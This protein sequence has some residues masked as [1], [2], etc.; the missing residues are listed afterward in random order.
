MT[1]RTIHSPFA[2]LLLRRLEEQGHDVAA[3]AQRFRLRARAGVVPALE[4]APRALHAL[5]ELAAE[6]LG[7]PD[8]GLHL[9]CA[10]PPGVFGVLELI[11]RYS[12]TL[13]D[14]LERL[15]RHSALVNPNASF[16]LERHDEGATFSHRIHGQPLAIGRHGNE[17]F[18]T[19]VV[20]LSREIAGSD[21]APRR[22]W[23]AHPAPPKRGALEAFFRAPLTFSAGENGIVFDARALDAPG[24]RADP[25]LMPILDHYAQA[26]EPPRPAGLDF[27]ERVREETLAALA[28]GAPRLQQIARRLL[29]S[30][31]T[32]QRRLR[33]R[34]TSFARL[35]DEV[36]QQLA[37]RLVAERT[38]PLGEI[39]FRSGYSDLRPFVRAYRRWTGTTPGRQRVDG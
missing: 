22:V 13:R 14:A 7:D 37:R 31:R 17:F 16:T 8:L 1:P 19:T 30:P 34:D 29:M 11:A 9:A 6:R 28:G 12:P 15:Q 38:L 20:L 35:V 39:A 36:R 3:L 23:F 4:L 26:A 10:R 18:L 2:A 21:W 33:E 25:E 5:S 32:L 27:L 24:R